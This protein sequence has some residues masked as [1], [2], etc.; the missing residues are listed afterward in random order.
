[1]NAR[2]LILALASSLLVAGCVSTPRIAVTGPSAFA[3]G[4][5]TYRLADGEAD[6]PAADAVRRA[7]S[8][9]GWR[10]TADRPAW[11]IEASYAVRPQKTGVYTDEGARQGEWTT[12]PVTPQWWSAGRKAHVLIL[13]LNS[14][15]EA[16][17]LRRVEARAVVADRK[18]EATLEALA[19]AV[20]AELPPAG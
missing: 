19:Q 3:A 6:E 18:A 4:T 13:T 1:M 20:A 17:N 5:A 12:A 2:H 10:E 14:L 7:L 9:R 15:G 16:Q 11:Q 8:A